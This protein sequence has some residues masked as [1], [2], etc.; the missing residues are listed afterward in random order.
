MRRFASF[1]RSGLQLR[2][3]FHY[4]LGDFW[5][6]AGERLHILLPLFVLG[7]QWS[8]K[9]LTLLDSCSYS[10]HLLSNTTL[11]LY[12]WERS[13][14]S[15]ADQDQLYVKELVAHAAANPG[16]C[17]YKPPIQ[18]ETKSHLKKRVYLKETASYS[19]KGSPTQAKKCR[20]MDQKGNFKEKLF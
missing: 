12:I 20:C 19:G 13:A 3:N 9:L 8:L 2:F 15:E 5:R 10:F 6:W 1:E 14:C 18:A 11:E 17:L 4:L 7:F 16:G